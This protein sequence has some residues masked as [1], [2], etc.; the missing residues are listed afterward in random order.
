MIQ[1][2]LTV[3]FEAVADLATFASRAGHDNRERA[4]NQAL[5]YYKYSLTPDVQIVAVD[6]AEKNYMDLTGD[7]YRP[8]LRSIKHILLMKNSM[9][10]QALKKQAGQQTI[11]QL[12]T[13][14]LAL[15]D[16]ILT[17][18]ESGRK[19]YSHNLEKNTFTKIEMEAPNP[20]PLS[21]FPPTV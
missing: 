7:P 1:A 6:E 10:V 18:M 14:V 4:L 2:E 20:T 17:A 13:R 5:A 8:G 16:D 15:Y 11:P 19:I 21:P 12:L 9:V 3:Q